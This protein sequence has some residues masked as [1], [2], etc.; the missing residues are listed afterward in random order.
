MS[1]DAIA[2]HE[3][4]LP[5]ET[6]LPGWR[7]WLCR[8]ENLLI[9][10]PLLAMMLLPVIEIF[11]RAVFRAGVSGSSVIVQHLTLLVGMFGGA[12]AAREGRLLALSPAQTFLKGRAKITAA[13]F[14][15]GIAAAVSFYLCV[16]SAEYVADVKPLGK[17]LVYGIP[18]WVIQLALPIGFGLIALRVI[19]RADSWIARGVTLVLAGAAAAVVTWLPLAPESLMIPALALLATA[20]LLGAPVFTALG[21]AALILFWGRELPV[22]SVP[23]KL[24]SLTTN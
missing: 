2:A 18:V 6:S 24:Y 14:S 1:S 7:R 23:L 12:I 10:I 22:Q 20:T 4:A 3:L 19:W 16:A 17:I 5:S 11:L 21:G 15:S 8:C 13:V 9:I